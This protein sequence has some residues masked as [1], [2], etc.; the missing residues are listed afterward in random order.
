MSND[1][2]FKTYKEMIN[3][4]NIKGIDNFGAL[5]MA[6]FLLVEELIDC[7]V[8]DTEDLIAKFEDIRWLEAKKD[9]FNGAFDVYIHYLNNQERKRHAS[10][11]YKQELQNK[12]QK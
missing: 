2:Q 9:G 4:A 7:Q 11:E 6:W 5:Q 10:A 12:R 3:S 8:I 1:T